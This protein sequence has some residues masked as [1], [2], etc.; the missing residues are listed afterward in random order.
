M[1]AKMNP[2]QAEMYMY[3]ILTVTYGELTVQRVK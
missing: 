1:S 3:I 2:A